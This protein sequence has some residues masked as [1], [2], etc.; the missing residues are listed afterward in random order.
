MLL[1]QVFGHGQRGGLLWMVE[2]AT[3]HMGDVLRRLGNVSFSQREL[4]IEEAVYFAF[5]GIARVGADKMTAERCFGIVEEIKLHGG[6]AMNDVTV[7]C[8]EDKINLSHGSALM[9]D[10]FVVGE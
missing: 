4:P 2:D 1:R 6:F 3:F 10:L 5:E 8:L 7:W 9:E